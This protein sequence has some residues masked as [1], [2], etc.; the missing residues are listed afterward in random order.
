MPSL[1]AVVRIVR[2]LEVSEAVTSG[3]G[4]SSRML[5]SL[6]RV[7]IAAN[8][9]PTVP[10]RRGEGAVCSDFGSDSDVVTRAVDVEDGKDGAERE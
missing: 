10:R 4:E 1:Q 5:K 2:D 6:I 3:D 8:F 7:V 9:P